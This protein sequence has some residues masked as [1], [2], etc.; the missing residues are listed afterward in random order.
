MIHIQAE[1]SPSSDLSGLLKR[2]PTPSIFFQD[3]RGA[4]NPTN[5]GPCP[6]LIPDSREQVSIKMSVRETA[7]PKALGN[8][9]DRT[10]RLP[11][12]QIPNQLSKLPSESVPRALRK[13]LRLLSAAVKGL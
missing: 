10:Y 4:T 9:E 11:G 8:G 13:K 2:V 7:S 6:C 12:P 1:G 5:H 3:D